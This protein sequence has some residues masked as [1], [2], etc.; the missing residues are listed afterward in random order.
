HNTSIQECRHW[1]TGSW[2]R[3]YTTW[4]LLLRRAFIWSEPLP[5]ALPTRRRSPLTADSAPT[6]RSGHPHFSHPRCAMAMQAVSRA[7]TM[8]LPFTT[9]LALSH[10]AFL[11]LL[12]GDPGAAAAYADET[13]ACSMEHRLAGPEHESR[14]TQG[15]LLAQGGNP[16]RGI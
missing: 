11:G 6:T 5:S 7:R 13:L 8:G 12:G 15:A 1:P 4:A 10:L 2:G 3:R 16:Q 14:F 9:A